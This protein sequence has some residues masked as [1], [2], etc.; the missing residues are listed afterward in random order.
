VRQLLGDR[1]RRFLSERRRE[2][3]RKQLNTGGPVELSRLWKG[4]TDPEHGGEVAMKRGEKQPA[5]REWDAE[6]QL[7]LDRLVLSED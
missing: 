4:G 2:H 5:R 7:G 1:S 3:Q 6:R